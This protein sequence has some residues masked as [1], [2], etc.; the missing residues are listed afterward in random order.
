MV[1]RVGRNMKHMNAMATLGLA[2]L[3]AIALPATGARPQSQEADATSKAFIKTAIQ[4][5]NAEIELGK[6]A[7]RKGESAAI[8]QFGQTLI[9]DH[10]K[11]NEEAKTAANAVG[12][13]P[14][15]ARLVT[16]GAQVK[17]QSQSGN[18]F[19]L[20]FIDAMISD[21]RNDIKNYQEQSGKNDAVGQ[22]AR[23]ALPTLQKHLQEAERI[24]Q[25]LNETT[26]SK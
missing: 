21:H 25:Q 24:Q 16:I 15:D 2:L 19:D 12:V 3:F 20:S 11:A 9:A 22:Y 10:E 26:G 14:P 4:G 23:Q 6:L 1:G 5:N 13:K 7:L 8:K 18:A 17:L